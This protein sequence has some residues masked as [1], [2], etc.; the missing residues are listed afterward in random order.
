[1]NLSDREYYEIITE[2]TDI[3][4]T[5][6]MDIPNVDIPNVDISNVDNISNGNDNTLNINSHILNNIPDIKRRYTGVGVLIMTEMNG[7]PFILLGRE[8]FKSLIYGGNYVIPMYEEFGGGIQKK[9]MSLEENALLELD[10]E[11]C[12]MFNF[13][14]ANIL[15]SPDYKYIDIPF[16]EDRMYRMY[17]MY[18]PNLGTKLNIFNNN[19]NIIMNSQSNYYKKRNYLEMD[20]ISLISL[21]EIMYRMNYPNENVFNFI[22]HKVLCVNDDIF[23]SRRLLKLFDGKYIKSSIENYNNILDFKSTS[24]NMTNAIMNNMNGY[25]FCDDSVNGSIRGIDICYDMF[26]KCY[27]K[28][29]NEPNNI[30]NLSFKNSNVYC[31]NINNDVNNNNNSNNSNNSENKKKIKYNF[32]IGTSYFDSF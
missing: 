16:R 9:S 24:N 26:N 7:R 5:D 8:K 23:I 13:S 27:V 19:Y 29:L 28:E 21:D 20:N 22:N 31:D 12:H 11:T 15:N 32:L 6:N 30:I 25:I 14:D 2:N 3:V 10:E 4:M 18:I 17:I 1:M